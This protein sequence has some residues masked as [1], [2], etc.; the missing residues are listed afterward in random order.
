MVGGLSLPKNVWCAKFPGCMMGKISGRCWQ[1]PGRCSTSR[2]LASYIPV[3]DFRL[4]LQLF[5]LKPLKPGVQANEDVI[6]AAPTGDA[7]TTSEWSTNLLPTKMRLILEMWWYVSVQI[8]QWC[9]ACKGLTHWLLKDVEI[10]WIVT[11]EV[12]LLNSKSWTIP[13][14]FALKRM[15]QIFIVN[16]GWG[17]GLVP[18]G[19]WAS[20]GP[21]LCRHL[22]ASIGH[23][24]SIL[25]C[26][27]KPMWWC[28]SS[29]GTYACWC[30]C[31]DTWWCYWV[32]TGSGNGLVPSG[33]KP[34]PEP[35]LTHMLSIS[36]NEFIV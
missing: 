32:N 16:I 11:L 36:H 34:L 4:V 23:S 3:T 12:K 20:V 21:V 29:E 26:N 19:T 8:P 14:S 5:L 6:G 13:M 2:T 33:T 1:I 7:P 30:Y 15:P 18:S 10:I 35:M 24:Q 31:I 25:K 28:I 17:I 22:M 9:S 27:R